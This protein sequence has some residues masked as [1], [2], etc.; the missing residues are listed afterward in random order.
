MAKDEWARA[1]GKYATTLEIIKYAIDLMISQ[2]R[3]YPPNLSEFLDLC[4]QCEPKKQSS[5]FHEASD[6]FKHRYYQWDHKPAC[7]NKEEQSHG[8]EISGNNTR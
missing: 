1:L 6:D 2:N 5:G 4:G 3:S 7:Y 8:S